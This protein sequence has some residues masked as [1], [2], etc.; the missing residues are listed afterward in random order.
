MDEL[1][2]AF[3]EIDQRSDLVEDLL[4][5]L[6]PD[7]RLV[8]R[9]RNQHTAPWRDLETEHRGRVQVGEENQD[10][11]LLLLLPEVLDQAGTPRS[12][13]FEPLHLVGVR[14]RIVVNPVGVLVERVDVARPCVREAA[15]CHAAHAVGAFRIVVLPRHVVLRAG[16]QDVDVVRGGQ[17]LG[18]QPAEMLGAAQHLGSVSLDDEG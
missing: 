10:V 13:L 8:V 4:E 17:T 16:R 5:D 15:D 11:V 18:E 14:V 7:G 1:A 2:L 12:L 6:E 3:G 9:G